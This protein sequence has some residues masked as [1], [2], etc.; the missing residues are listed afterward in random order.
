MTGIEDASSGG[1]TRGGAASSSETSVAREPCTVV[2]RGAGDLGTGIALCLHRARVRVVLTELRAPLAVRRGVAFAEAVYE[3][4]W[5]VEGVEA[6]RSESAAQAIA[7]AHESIIPVLVAPD[8]SALNDLDADA[9]VDARLTKLPPEPVGLHA[10]LVIGLGPG[11]TAGVNCDAV[12]ETQR[13]VHPGEG[14]LDRNGAGR[15]G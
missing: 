12:V 3:G 7:L 15:H 1:A 5:T 9:L 14:V 6:R 13:G 4:S 11:F 2:V 10:R 8:L